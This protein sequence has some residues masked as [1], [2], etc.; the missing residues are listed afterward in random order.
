MTINDYVIEHN[1]KPIPM[2][3]HDWDW[4][5]REYQGPGDRRCGTA[6]SRED[7]E[8]QIEELEGEE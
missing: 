3:N 5:H 7:A 6:A 8:R 2:R 4:T 1:P